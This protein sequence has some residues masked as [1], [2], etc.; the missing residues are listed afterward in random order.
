MAM[1]QRALNLKNPV[2]LLGIVFAAS[3]LVGAIVHGFPDEQLMAGL[4]FLV[5]GWLYEYRQRQNHD[6]D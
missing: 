2:I 1:I 4:L 6:G 3:G 5:G